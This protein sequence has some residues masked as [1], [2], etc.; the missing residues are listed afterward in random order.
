MAGLGFSKEALQLFKSY[1]SD[2]EQY[3]EYEGAISGSFSCAL[4]VFSLPYLSLIQK[5]IWSTPTTSK[6]FI[7]LNVRVTVDF[8][9]QILS[10][11]MRLSSPL[12]LRNAKRY[13]LLETLGV[14]GWS[15]VILNTYSMKRKQLRDLE[16]IRDLGLM[17]DKEIIFKQHTAKMTRKA[18]RAPRFISCN[19]NFKNIL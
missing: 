15:R 2:R 7:P 8:C 16:F 5:A 10:G 14:Q 9:K 1:L 4:G 18:K 6:Y 11:A 13:C 17:L 19:S 3:V 12:K